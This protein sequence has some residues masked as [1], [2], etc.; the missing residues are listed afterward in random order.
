MKFWI[1]KKSRCSTTEDWLINLGERNF[2]IT[3]LRVV[4]E[5]RSLP[6]S[7]GPSLLSS[8]R[9]VPESFFSVQACRIT[10]LSQQFRQTLL[11]EMRSKRSALAS[12]ACCCTCERRKRSLSVVAR[13]HLATPKIKTFHY[14]SHKQGPGD[15]CGIEQN[16]ICLQARQL[17]IK[18]FKCDKTKTS[19]TSRTVGTKKYL[20]DQLG[21]V[22]KPTVTT[23]TTR[24]LRDCGVLAAGSVLEDLCLTHFFQHGESA[25]NWTTSSKRKLFFP[26]DWR[27]TRW[28][29]QVAVQ[30]RRYFIS[31]FPENRTHSALRESVTVWKVKAP[32][33]NGSL[34]NSFHQNKDEEWVDCLVFD[35]S[36]P[37]THPA[38][39]V[40]LD[41]R[42][43]KTREH[44][45]AFIGLFLDNFSILKSN[46]GA[47]KRKLLSCCL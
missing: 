22:L 47:D 44:V 43:G 2:G 20:R 37:L 25:H 24:T 33:I 12:W 40:R 30:R 19:N 34:S 10:Q 26:F 29:L 6:S 46:F 41:W 32:N 14:F 5:R 1:W 36:L 42:A 3:Y 23:N 7:L 39:Q 11:C 38:I 18:A 31:A 9:E 21:L 17:S 4:C 13:F 15:G 28:G 16:V 35:F 8:W 27:S 45:K